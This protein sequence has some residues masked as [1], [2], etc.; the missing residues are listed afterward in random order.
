[1]G[2]KADNTSPKDGAQRQREFKKRQRA[3]GKTDFRAWISNEEAE[4][5]KK[6]LAVLRKLPLGTYQCR[7]H[8]EDQENNHD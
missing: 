6:L 1:M 4:M 5:L 3:A 2:M 7:F 8:R